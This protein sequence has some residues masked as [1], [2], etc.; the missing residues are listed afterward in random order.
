MKAYCFPGQGPQDTALISSLS[1]LPD[2]QKYQQQILNIT[3]FDLNNLFSL[4]EEEQ[5]NAVQKNEIA[6]LITI[7]FSLIEYEQ[8]QKTKKPDFLLGYSVGQYVALHIAGC[9]DVESL[10]KLVWQRSMLMNTANEARSGRMAAIIGMAVEDVESLCVK[11]D[12][13]ISNFNARGQYTIAGALK[14]LEKAVEEALEID[15]HKSLLINTEG[16]WHSDFMK[17]AEEPFATL[18][19]NMVFQEPKISIVDNVTGLLM[20]QNPE[21]IKQQL[22]KHLSHAVQWEQSIRFLIDQN[23]KEFIEVGYGNMLTKFGFFISRDASFMTAEK[24][25]KDKPCVA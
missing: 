8:L 18:L 13:Q 3:G 4:S 7:L 9:F 11:H 1:T 2:C 20:P 25:L 21:E 17:A 14:N 23:V 16:A 15:A 5:K 6:S 24:L 19:E 10:I 22:V 12:L